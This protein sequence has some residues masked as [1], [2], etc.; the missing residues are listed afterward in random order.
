M[1]SLHPLTVR[2]TTLAAAG[3]PLPARDHPVLH[4]LCGVS[5]PDLV[6]GDLVQSTV[7]WPHGNHATAC[8]VIGSPHATAKVRM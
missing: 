6:V 3:P 7:M 1:T 8:C 2:A 5:L 4:S